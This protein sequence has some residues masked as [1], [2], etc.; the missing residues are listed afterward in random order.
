M[1][2][3]VFSPYQGILSDDD[4]MAAVL[5]STAADFGHG[6]RKA[7]LTD[8]SVISPG[9][10]G[11]QQV[12][13]QNQTVLD[14]GSEKVKVYLRV[15]PFGETELSKGED[16][17]CVKI[18]TADT[19]ILK[20][21]KDSFTMKNMERGIGHATHK[22]S[23]SQIFGPDTTQKEFFSATMKE[24][25][26][27]VLEG[28]NRLLYTY[29]VTNSGKTYTIQGTIRDGGILPR[30]LAVIFNSIRGKLY[31]KNDF[32]PSSCNELVWLDSKQIRLE[33]AK[34]TALLTGLREE[35]FQTPL[36]RIGSG[37]VNGNGD[38]SCSFDSGFAGL[39]SCSQLEGMYG[40]CLYH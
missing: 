35:D 14:D 11:V 5:E 6:I 15:R 17:G 4:E 16:Q 7:L 19:L 27:D 37:N 1:T 9:A 40:K 32:K 22:F 2:A 23:F 38:T 31:D 18:E 36:K 8:F 10:E 34:K 29:G 21:P 13:E 12:V 25:V 3:G 28:H 26:K 24:I 20:A 30:S 39:S 33:E